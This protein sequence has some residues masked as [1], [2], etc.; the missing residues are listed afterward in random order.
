MSTP[1]TSRARAYRRP[2]IGLPLC[3]PFGRSVAAF[4]LRHRLPTRL[5][6]RIRRWWSRRCTDSCPAATPPLWGLASCAQSYSS[7]PCTDVPGCHRATSH[8]ADCHIRARSSSGRRVLPRLLR[9]PLPHLYRL[10]AWPIM[11]IAVPT[12]Y[13]VIFI[14]YDFAASVITSNSTS[15]L[16][17]PPTASVRAANESSLSG[18]DLA[19]L[20]SYKNLSEFILSRVNGRAIKV[21]SYLACNDLESISS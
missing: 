13:T 1:S 8:G 6:R 19:Q 21:G 9:V 10:R 5:P 15:L 12:A 7:F 3:C 17:Q 2:S 14:H 20:S 16:L 18:L 11:A 4:R